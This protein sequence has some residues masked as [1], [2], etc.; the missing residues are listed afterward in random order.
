MGLRSRWRRFESCRGRCHGTK[1]Q[2]QMALA[3]FV[4]EV[5]KD[6]M[7]V[8]VEQISGRE[9]RLG[10]LISVVARTG[11]RRGEVVGLQWGDVDLATGTL[12][13][14]HFVGSDGPSG[15]LRVILLRRTHGTL[16]P[17]G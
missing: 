13:P 1:K 4:T 17:W 2:A 5:S 6:R 11:C 8:S 16:A 14:W 9:A 7:I 15:N 10:I 3:A 12:N